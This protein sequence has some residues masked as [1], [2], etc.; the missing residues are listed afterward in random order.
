[1]KTKVLSIIMAAILVM[2]CIVAYA[3]QSA[4]TELTS[5]EELFEKDSIIDITINIDE[6]DLQDMYAYP[7]NEEYHS[8]D[9]TVNGIEMKN[10]GIRT[11]GNMTLSSV[12]ASDSDR[13]S[14]R[15]KFN[16]YVK[17]QT[18]LGLNELCLN[19][20]Y[21]DASYMRE[22]LHYEML[23][24]MGQNVP[25]TVFCNL[26]IN[27]EL[28]GFYLAV[29]AIDDSF[30]ERNYGEDQKGNLYKMEEGASL[31]YK[32]DENYSYGELK[33]GSDKEGTGLKN[34]IKKLD[35]GDKN[36]IESVLDVDSALIYIAANTVLCNYDSY[37]SGMKH[38]YYLYENENGIFSVLT[39]D[40]NMSFGG[41]ESNTD[42]G[43]DTPIVSGSMEDS[44]LISR[45]LA[46]TEYKERYYG[47]IKEMMAWLEN[48]E[49]RVNEVKSVIKPYVENDP[50]A[51]YTV[52][53]F[54]KATTLQTET[55]KNSDKNQDK[56]NEKSGF[57]GG[58]FGNGKSILNIMA[59]RLENLK[60]QFNGTAEK[61]TET[62]EGT[63]FGGFGRNNGD[64][65]RPEG[66][67]MGDMKDMPDFMMGNPDNMPMP[68]FEGE[69][70]NFPK[71]FKGKMPEGDGKDRMGKGEKGFGFNS[72]NESKTIRVHVNGH[73]V[74]F[75]TDPVL[76]NDTTLVG[77]RSILEVLGAEVV[78]DET[79]KT[80]TA[81]KDDTKIVLTIGEDTAYVNGEATALTVAPEIIGNSTM[82]PI[83]FVS[84][85]MG[86]KVSWDGDTKLITVNSK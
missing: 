50:S 70:G 21:S 45:L 48:F 65:K 79:T 15:I 42:V 40:V 13:Y 58:G 77:F 24:E 34:L 82:I 73:I 44:P 38:N 69:N 9:I 25:E 53:E 11:K 75:E 61:S 76:E 86:M 16:K 33:S 6:Q 22:Y 81:T 23:R 43:I 64:F 60:A 2:S 4:N 59:E 67:E 66:M 72:K 55:A 17:G 10:S 62:G 8:A 83:R 52:E 51:F 49:T 36:E 84:E 47:Y 19:N 46:I 78:W 1:M 32:E 27:G 26:Y 5:Y 3:K 7:K 63:G 71:D 31:V 14:F 68:D 28:Y 57:G 20:G 18:L 37:N 80:V 85:N 35:S 41:R 56:P 30:L 29:E 12:A 54:E 74:S 39:W